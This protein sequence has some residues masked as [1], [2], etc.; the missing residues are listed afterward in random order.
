MGRCFGFFDFSILIASMGGYPAPVAFAGERVSTGPSTGYY[1]SKLLSGSE[2]GAKKKANHRKARRRP[3]P[4]ASSSP[5]RQP[6]ENV[7]DQTEVSN[8]ADQQ[9][10]PKKHP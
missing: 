10:A 1:D 4:T 6:Q 3:K 2:F 7:T 8:Q 5:S 9:A